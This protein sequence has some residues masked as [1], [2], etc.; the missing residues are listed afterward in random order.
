MTKE[1][2]S[3]RSSVGGLTLSADLIENK[4]NEDFFFYLVIFRRFDFFRAKINKFSKRS[5]RFFDL[6][7]LK[8][9]IQNLEFIEKIIPTT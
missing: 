1:V 4:I 2:L 7:I 6:K 5:F 8:F 3:F 9:S